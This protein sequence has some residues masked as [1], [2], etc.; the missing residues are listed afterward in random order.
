MLRFCIDARPLCTSVS[1]AEILYQGGTFD[2]PLGFARGFGKN[3]QAPG[4]Q[5]KSHRGKP[6]PRFIQ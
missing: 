2:F 1:I 3:G 5:G 4:A 6:T